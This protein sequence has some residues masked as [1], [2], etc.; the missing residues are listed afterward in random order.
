MYTIRPETVETF[1]NDRKVRFPRFQRKQTWK[2]QQNLKLAISLFKNYPIGVTIINREVINKKVTRWL[3]DGRQRRQALRLISENPENIYMWAKSFF[4]L[5]NNYDEQDI[6]NVFWKG[7]E[8]YLNFQD[9]WEIDQDKEKGIITNKEELEEEYSGNFE[10]EDFEDSSTEPN[11]SAEMPFEA[12]NNLNTNSLG[13]LSELLQIIQKIHSVKIINKNIVFSSG[14]TKP[15][16]FSSIISNLI[17]I[18]NDEKKILNGKKITTFIKEYR[19]DILDTYDSNEITLKNF[20]DYMLSRYKLDEKQESKLKLEIEKNWIYIVNSIEIV[21]LI[22]NRLQESYIGIIQTEDLTATDSQ[23]IFKLINDAGTP[24]SAVEILSAKPAWNRPVKNHSQKLSK[25]V[26]D[27]YDVINTDSIGVVRWD[28]PAT[29]YN[30]LDNFDAILPILG[31]QTKLEKNITLGFKMISGLFQ[32]GIKKEDLSK[33]SN[34]DI[35]WEEDIDILVS[36]LC[37]MGRILMESNYFKCMKSWNQT[38]MELTSDAI[39]L[40]FIFITYKDFIKKDRPVGNNA[41]KFVNNAIKLADKLMYEY[42]TKK[43]RGSS[44]SKIANNLSSF[45]NEN[46]IY[47]SID[48]KIWKKL[49]LDIFNKYQIEEDPI[50]FDLMKSLVMHQYCV[51]QILGPNNPKTKINIDHIIPKSLFEKGNFKKDVLFNLCPLEER[52]NKKKSNKK[53]KDINDPWL[54][55]QIER[56]ASIPHQKFEDFSYPENLDNLMNYRKSFFIDEFI[57][58]RIKLFNT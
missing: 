34:L 35:K 9:Q 55:Q 48:E 29:F 21:E 56:Y 43:W 10:D 46:D 24:L 44:D 41:N 23:M 53:L 17:Y 39:T 6:Q 20:I 30:R 31:Y 12:K 26:K 42:M 28:Y 3:L 19:K 36:D 18:D 50:K 52:D 2:D 49:L 45:V 38:F 5:K 32:S 16:D 22:E 40:N 4:K 15:F 58:N 13:N 47:N 51:A 14:Y 54:I 11:S 27:L 7:I 33:L 8:D 37:L 57:S 1:I 25:Y